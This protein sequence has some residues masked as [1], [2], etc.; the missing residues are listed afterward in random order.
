MC[1]D[2]SLHAPIEMIQEQVPGLVVDPQLQ[3]DLET[4]QHVLAQSFRKYPVVVSEDGVP[5]LRLFEWGVIADYM[6]TPEKIRESRTS[7][8]NARSEKLQDKR[9]VW[10]RLR[11]KRCL[12]PVSGFF[13]HREI[14]GWKN[15]VPYFIRVQDKPLFFLGGLYNYSPLPDI[16]TGEVK[17]TFTVITRPAND[18]MKLIHNGGPNKYRMPMVLSHEDQ[19]KWLDPSMKDEE[20][21]RMTEQEFPAQKMEAWPVFSIRTT[22]PRPDGLLSYERFKYDNLPE[23]GQDGGLQLTLI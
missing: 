20:L 19:Q 1:Y 5:H 22:K 11:N 13:E 8:C 21:I 3:L 6:N 2:V 14:S 17:G 12:V 23:L 7:M 18:L 15:K 10:Y 4:H 9:S 16:E